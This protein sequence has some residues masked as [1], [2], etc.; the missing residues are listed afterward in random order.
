MQSHFDWLRRSQTGA[1]LLA[2]LQY[3]ATHPGLPSNG[4]E[5]GPPYSALGGP[6]LRCWIYPRSTKKRNAYYCL[7]CQAILDAARKLGS[8]SRCSVVIWGF[9]NQLPRQFHS[10]G[11][12]DSHVLDPY[13][14]DENHFMLMLY[15][16]ELKPWL[17]ELVIYNGADLKGFIQIFPTTGA[18]EPSMGDLLCRIIQNEARFP[19]DRLRVRFF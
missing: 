13:I 9:V 6:C 4:G 16:R 18:S 14:H 1:E 2:T 5:I 10:G 7:T 17:Q 19:M 12:R 11:F 8:I 15:Q 3:L